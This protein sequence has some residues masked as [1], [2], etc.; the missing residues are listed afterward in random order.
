[1]AEL[2]EQAENDTSE[3]QSLPPSIAAA[4]AIL[5]E[6]KDLKQ[7]VNTLSESVE[8]GELEIAEEPGDGRVSEDNDDFG[9]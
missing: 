5:A 3:R 6:V 2:I 1:M 4:F 9:D 7:I 8:L